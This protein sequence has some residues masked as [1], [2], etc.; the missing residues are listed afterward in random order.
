MPCSRFK[1]LVLTYNI[2]SI[3]QNA[4][5]LASGH[6]I[7]FPMLRAGR[8]LALEKSGKGQKCFTGISYRVI[9]SIPVLAVFSIVIGNDMVE[10]PGLSELYDSAGHAG[11][12]IF[13]VF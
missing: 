7:L 3:I 13:Q 1:S 4:A 10:L 8:C 6:Q 5:K 2:G 9:K 11:F 12:D